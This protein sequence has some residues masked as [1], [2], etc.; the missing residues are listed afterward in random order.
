MSL[1]A[2]LATSPESGQF[3]VHS[4]HRKS[5]FTK[6]VKI[7]RPIFRSFL[8]SKEIHANLVILQYLGSSFTWDKAFNH[9][10]NQRLLD[11]I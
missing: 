8:S 7:L 11:R 6:Q 9:V 2:T 10:K 5:W 4:Q 1:V 3:R